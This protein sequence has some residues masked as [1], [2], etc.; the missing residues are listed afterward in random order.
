MPELSWRHHTLVQSLLS[1]GPL[2]ED[3]FHSI[4]A[5]ITGKKPGTHPKIFSDY[6]LKINKELAYVQFEL[7]G[8]RNQYDGKVYYGVVNN[9][10]DEQSKL[11]TKYSVPQIAFYKGVIEAIVQDVAGHGSISNI[12]ALNIRLENQVQTGT[13]SQ[14]QGGPSHVPPAFKNFSIS[15]KEK[16]LDDL[17]R[18]QWLCSTPDG[19]IGLGVRSFL[20]LRSWF[21]NNYVPSCDICNEA[22][23]KAELCENEGCTVRI[24]SYC[25]KKKFSQRRVERV[26][27]GCGTEWKFL[28][29]EAEAVEEE[30]EE[31]CR[32]ESQPPSSEPTMKEP[33]MKK[34]LRSCKPEEADRVGAGPSRASIPIPVSKRTRTSARLR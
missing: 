14:S 10:A 8:C 11:G 20:D 4:F 7:K 32:N 26:C 18:D 30:E 28:P 3:D 13:E 6:L 5:G 16:T 24:H 2:K 17:V 23:V 21:R 31:D 25:L 19:N 27:P 33:T 22:G 1:R 12:H 29:S 9:V 34:R 15:Q